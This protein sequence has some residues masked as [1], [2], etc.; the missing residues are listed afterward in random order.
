MPQNLRAPFWLQSD[1][2]G[3]PSEVLVLVVF[4]YTSADLSRSARDILLPTICLQ[5]SAVAF[6]FVDEGTP[7]KYFLG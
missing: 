5:L 6:A 7:E 1:D 4:A 2:V 3:V